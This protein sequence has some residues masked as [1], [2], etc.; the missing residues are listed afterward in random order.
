[1]NAHERSRARCV[2]T[3]HMDRQ[4]HR[5]REARARQVCRE[6]AKVRVAFLRVDDSYWGHHDFSVTA[7]N[8]LDT[9]ADALRARSV[10]RSERS[11]R[12][13]SSIPATSAKHSHPISGARKSRSGSR[14]EPEE[15]SIT[16]RRRQRPGRVW[17]H[18][19]IRPP[20]PRSQDAARVTVRRRRE[21]PCH[22]G[23]CARRLS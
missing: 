18:R 16:T 15:A 14:T 5:C 12:P 13:Q 19:R 2:A 20:R 17:A 9:R 22:R 3:A 23:A 10:S 7:M 8:S 4:M 21:A 1:M 6:V 11:R